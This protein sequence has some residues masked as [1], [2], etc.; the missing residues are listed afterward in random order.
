MGVAPL[1][2]RGLSSQGTEHQGCDCRTGHLLNG[3]VLRFKWISII[4]VFHGGVIGSYLS[5]IHIYI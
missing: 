2:P 4:H 3:G 5:E 1:F